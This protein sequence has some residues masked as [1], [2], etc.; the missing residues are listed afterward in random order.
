M[1][2]SGSLLRQHLMVQRKSQQSP[3]IF[4]TENR[5]HDKIITTYFVSSKR[6]WILGDATLVC[7]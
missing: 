3:E 2:R 5:E 4:E 1:S 6:S 7:P